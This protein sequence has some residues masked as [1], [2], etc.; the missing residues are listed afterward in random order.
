MPDNP[1]KKLKRK[2]CRDL[3]LVYSN[4]TLEVSLVA[5]FSLNTPNKILQNITKAY[6]IEDCINCLIQIKNKKRESSFFI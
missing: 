2:W 4:S 5:A 1:P 6:Y 3:L